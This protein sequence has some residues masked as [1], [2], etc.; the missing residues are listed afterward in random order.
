MT[1]G[2]NNNSRR[3]SV[4]SP[5]ATL[6]PQRGKNPSSDWSAVVRHINCPAG[7]VHPVQQGGHVLLCTLRPAPRPA[8]VSGPKWSGVPSGMVTI[9]P[10]PPEVRGGGEV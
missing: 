5:A 6:R 4:Q 2:S 10:D 7:R 8:L 3:V 9:C 1:A